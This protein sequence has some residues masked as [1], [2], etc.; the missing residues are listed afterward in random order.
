MFHCHNLRHE[1]NE[2]EARPR[3]RRG[4][5]ARSA[6]FLLPYSIRTA[7]YAY[8]VCLNVWFCFVL[9]AHATVMR[10]FSANQAHTATNLEDPGFSAI[11]K[12]TFTTRELP[13][14]ATD[15]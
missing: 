8:I 10:S 7:W 5:W 9:L 2:S 12:V 13:C 6:C 15:R 14:T 11:S 1:D 4:W 3:G